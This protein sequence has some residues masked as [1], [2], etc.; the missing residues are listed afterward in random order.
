[1]QMVSFSSRS[2]AA[3]G[4]EGGTPVIAFR[5]GGVYRYSGVPA[6]VAPALFS[7]PSK[8][9]YYQSFVRG[10]YPSVRVG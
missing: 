7:A 5:G 4:H 10:R 3:A 8:G 2:I 6:P 9:R 1:M